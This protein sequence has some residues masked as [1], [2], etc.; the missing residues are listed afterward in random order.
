[1]KRSLLSSFL[2]FNWL[3]SL[4]SEKG[5][6]GRLQIIK[7]KQDVTETELSSKLVSNRDSTFSLWLSCVY[8]II[9]QYLHYSHFFLDLFRVNNPFTQCENSSLQSAY[10]RSPSSLDTF[11]AVA[12]ELHTITVWC[13]GMATTGQAERGSRRELGQ[14]ERLEQE[15]GDKQEKDK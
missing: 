10:K 14:G 1:M 4:C 13:G 15:E 5:W 7:E 12:I 11:I 9:T 2:K 6:W 8:S 3:Y